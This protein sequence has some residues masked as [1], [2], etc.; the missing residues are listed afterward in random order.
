MISSSVHMDRLLDVIPKTVGHGFMELSD[1]KRV[2][3]EC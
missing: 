1:S 3:Q 2:F